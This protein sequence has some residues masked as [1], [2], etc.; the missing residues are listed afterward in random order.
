MLTQSQHVARLKAPKADIQTGRH[1][2]MSWIA[3]DQIMFIDH[4]LGSL[5]INEHR[6]EPTKKGKRGELIYPLYFYATITVSPEGRSIAEAKEALD[7]FTNFARN[8]HGAI[9]WGGANYEFVASLSGLGVVRRTEKHPLSFDKYAPDRRREARQV[10][11]DIEGYLTGNV[12]DQG[13]ELTMLSERNRRRLIG[14]LFGEA[15]GKPP[16]RLLLE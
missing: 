10:N 6:G 5:T 16:S 8:R 1:D 14:L 7:R 3:N 2:S 9:F 12:A 15:Q 4:R 11:C 13:R